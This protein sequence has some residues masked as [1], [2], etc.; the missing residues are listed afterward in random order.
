MLLVFFHLSL[1]V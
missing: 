1:L